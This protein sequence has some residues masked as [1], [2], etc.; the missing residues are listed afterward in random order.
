MAKQKSPIKKNR[1][2]AICGKA[3][4]IALTPAEK[5]EFEAAVTRRPPSSGEII[6][7]T[8]PLN[9]LRS[10][11]EVPESFIAP[12]GLLIPPS[13][14]SVGIK[15]LAGSSMCGPAAVRLPIQIGGSHDLVVCLNDG[16]LWVSLVKERGCETFLPARGPCYLDP[17]V[18]PGGRA[19]TIEWNLPPSTVASNRSPVTLT[20]AAMTRER[21]YDYRKALAQARSGAPIDAASCANTVRQTTMY[22]IESTETGER[23]T[24]EVHACRESLRLLE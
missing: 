2:N 4:R 9:A 5:K 1:R 17:F 13:K 12:D 15:Y 10:L 24:F 18:S 11:F 19:K 23:F 3:V 7:L 20:P 22:R 21:G 6:A 14:P 16:A 8:F